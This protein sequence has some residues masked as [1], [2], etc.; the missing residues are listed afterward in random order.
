MI[1]K[2]P[3]YNPVFDDPESEKA[4]ELVL[5]CTKA[6]RSLMAGYTVKDRAE[7]IIQAFN[8][9]AL[10]TCQNEVASIKSLSGKGSVAYSV[11]LHVK[12]CVDMDAEIAKAQKKL[13]RTDTSLQKQEKALADPGYK[14]K[15]S[16]AVQESD[17]KR[18]ADTKQEKSSLEETV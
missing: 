7:V 4:Y 13:E 1:A 15:V 2:Y 12:G 10:K 14:E 11:F 17:Q 6:T 9:E 18:L 5:D 16:A 3:T 8:E